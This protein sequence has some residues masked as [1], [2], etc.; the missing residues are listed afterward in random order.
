MSIVGGLVVHC[1]SGTAGW[2]AAK[3]VGPR[4]FA[5]RRTFKPVNLVVALGGTGILW[6]GWNGF[7]G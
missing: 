2:I 5:D 4:H 3:I 1:S 6:I 7:N